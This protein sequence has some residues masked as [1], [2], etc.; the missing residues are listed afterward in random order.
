MF[1]DE[2]KQELV[3]YKVGNLL[4]R[5]GALEQ[6]L[7]IPTQETR[8]ALPFWD[9]KMDLVGDVETAWVGAER[10]MRN[11]L[12]YNFSYLSEEKVVEVEDGMLKRIIS[13]STQKD[14]AFIYFV[15]IIEV[16]QDFDTR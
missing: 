16:P 2:L 14:T 9:F 12:K 8:V 6:E 1:G 3:V 5:H 7:W 10:K 11:M 4:W 13:H 15:G